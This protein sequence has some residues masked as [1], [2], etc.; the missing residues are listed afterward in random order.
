MRQIFQEIDEKSAQD[1]TQREH[2][3]LKNSVSALKLNLLVYY[4]ILYDFYITI[5]IFIII[6]LFIYFLLYYILFIYF[7]L[8]IY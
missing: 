8:I 6:L 5:I 3:N 7:H 1:S 4:Y 2:S